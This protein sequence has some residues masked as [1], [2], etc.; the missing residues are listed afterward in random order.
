MVGPVVV[1]AGGSAHSRRWDVGVGFVEVIRYATEDVVVD[2]RLIVVIGAGVDAVDHRGVTNNEGV[3]DFMQQCVE[4][5]VEA[6]YVMPVRFVTTD[7]ESGGGAGRAVR[8]GGNERIG[9]G[10]F[11]FVGDVHLFPDLL[12]ERRGF[13]V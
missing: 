1:V 8:T 7:C 6:A 2:T 4:E 11:G 9:R 3:S 10:T 12:D 5:G 13:C